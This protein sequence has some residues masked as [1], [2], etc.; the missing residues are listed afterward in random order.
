MDEHRI[1]QISLDI[2]VGNGCDGYYLAEDVANE[3]NRRGFLVIGQSFAE[4]MTQIYK[5]AYKENYHKLFEV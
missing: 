5:E 2:A 3:L 4:D 1:L